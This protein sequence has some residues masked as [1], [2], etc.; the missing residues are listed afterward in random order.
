MGPALQGPASFSVTLLSMSSS[1]R[2]ARGEGARARIT[3]RGRGTAACSRRDPRRQAPIKYSAAVIDADAVIAGLLTERPGPARRCRGGDPGPAHFAS[4]GNLVARQGVPQRNRSALIEQDAH[5][6]RSQR[7]AGSVLQDGPN[8]FERDTVKPLDELRRGGAVLQILEHC[9]HR[10]AGAAKHPSST[11]ALRIPLDRGA[12]GPVDHERNR[13][14]TS[15]W[16][17]NRRTNPKLHDGARKR[18]RSFH[19]A[20][21]R[22]RSVRS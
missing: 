19:V 18:L 11:D 2:G 6:G 12:G 5:S 8:L 3:Q 14:I 16:R 22:I 13:T 10:D 1:S 21:D 15:V 17:I 20:G 4:G 7:A 9:S